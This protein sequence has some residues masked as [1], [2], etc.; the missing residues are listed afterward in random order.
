MLAGS[1][2]TGPGVPYLELNVANM[3]SRSDLGAAWHFVRTMDTNKIVPCVFFDEI[4]A[5]VDG[6]FLLQDLIMPMN[7][8]AVIHDGAKLPLGPAVFVFAGSKLFEPQVPTA[9]RRRSSAS[10][11]CVAFD[12]WRQQ[13]ETQI[14]A[15]GVAPIN[16]ARRSASRSSAAMPHVVPKIRDFLDRIDRCVIFPDPGVAFD[17]ITD[18]VRHLENVDLV[19]SMVRRHFPSVSSI[20]PTAA[21]ALAI[22]LR[23]GAS[24]RAAERLAFTAIVPT[25]VTCFR[26]EHLSSEGQR[27]LTADTRLKLESKFKDVLWATV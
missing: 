13:K 8:A 21:T 22:A 18:D 11:R 27:L 19:L 3:P 25:G 14:R 6:R 1:P 9:A 24:K 26:F 17:G 23:G 7:D 12:E 5:E 4:D 2:S 20:E 15:L 16:A 10:L